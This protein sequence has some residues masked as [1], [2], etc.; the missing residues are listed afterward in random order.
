MSLL[1]F[2]VVAD[3]ME[4]P[5][6]DDSSDVSLYELIH[7]F[8]V[9]MEDLFNLSE[10]RHDRILQSWQ[11][12]GEHLDLDKGAAH[13]QMPARHKASAA[14]SS[15]APARSFS[16]F[17]EWQPL[18]THTVDYIMMQSSDVGTVHAHACVGSPCRS[19]RRS[20][21][22]PGGPSASPAS[23]A[24]Y[25]PGWCSSSAPARMERL[26]SS[27]DDEDED[28]GWQYDAEGNKLLI[29][30]CLAL[31][32]PEDFRA[33]L[34]SQTRALESMAS[35]HHFSLAALRDLG[36]R[37]RVRKKVSRATRSLRD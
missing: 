25:S 29:S 36:W 5:V 19:R 17:F 10:G 9:E 21:A 2:E 28:E 22:S 1:G 13:F 12:L 35:E 32:G 33:H 3:S 34:R 24:S 11:S 31:R 26:P 6:G 15:G 23:A 16:D 7:E 14:S 27:S 18:P 20:P 8:E 4:N 30:R 37:G